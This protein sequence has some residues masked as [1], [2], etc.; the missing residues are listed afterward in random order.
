MDIPAGLRYHEAGSD[1]ISDDGP[2]Q[3]VHMMRISSHKESRAPRGSEKPVETCLNGC[4]ASMHAG[5]RAVP[6]T[7]HEIQRCSP[8]LRVPDFDLTG[9]G[10]SVNIS[11]R[12]PRQAHEVDACKLSLRGPSLPR[13]SVPF[14]FG[15]FSTPEH[16]EALQAFHRAYMEAETKNSRMRILS[17]MYH[18]LQSA[19]GRAIAYF[20]HI[21]F[22][23]CV[24]QNQP[25]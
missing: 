25:T 11:M 2:S 10:K 8:G 5:D 9:A 18:H 17:F 4:E 1:G 20:F 21:H 12:L 3:M 15:G 19:Q 23:P 7:A 24:L 14:S 22:D 16:R 13:L 6:N